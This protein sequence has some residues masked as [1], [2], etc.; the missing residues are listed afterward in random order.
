MDEQTQEI[1][2]WKTRCESLEQQVEG[3]RI[4]LAELRE[5]RRLLLDCVSPINPKDLEIDWE[6]ALAEAKSEEPLHVF[7]DKLERGEV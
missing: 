4:D 6:A 7:I 3:M 2:R 1:Q 5:Q